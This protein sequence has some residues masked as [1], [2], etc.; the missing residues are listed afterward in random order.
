[1]TSTRW[2]S[3]YA[4]PLRHRERSRR[5]LPGMRR[6]PVLAVAL[7][8]LLA[9]ASAARA[10]HPL[11]LTTVRPAGAAPPPLHLTTVGLAGAD[12]KTEPRIAVGPDDRRWVVTNGDGAAIVYG[13]RDGGL[14]RA[15]PPP[16]PQP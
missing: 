7:L 9:T 3:A 14:T 10:A 5:S 8:S 15:R 4:P 12:D 13:S 1:M 6:F 11:Q 2:S 16:A